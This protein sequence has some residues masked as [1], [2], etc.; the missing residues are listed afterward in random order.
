MIRNN[1]ISLGIHLF[2][3]LMSVLLIAA[4]SNPVYLFVVVLLA[5]AAYF[6]LGYQFLQPKNMGM[7]NFLSVGLVSLIGLLIGLYCWL[8]PGQMGF[9]WMIFLAYNVPSLVLAQIF[10]FSPNPAGTLWFFLVPSLLLWL[11][12]QVKDLRNRRRVRSSETMK[13]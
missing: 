5:F 13:Q 10:Q 4:E 12:L 6:L 11:S 2:I 3:L 9:N 7:M 1:L 8:V